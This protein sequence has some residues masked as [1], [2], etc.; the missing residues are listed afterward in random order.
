MTKY[1]SQELDSIV[2]RKEGVWYI[3]P[4]K[5]LRK[6]NKVT[7]DAFPLFEQIN[8]I[9]IVNHE[10]W[11]YSPNLP[12]WDIDVWYM[13]PGQEDNLITLEWNRFVDLYDPKTKKILNFEISYERIKLGWEIIHK[14]PAILGWNI[15]VFHKN[16][17]PNGSI[18]QNFAV[19]DDKFDLDTEFNIYKLNTKTGEYS[20]ARFWKED[21]PN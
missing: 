14:W 9:D 19:R 21:Q 12:N 15:W 8:W 16:Y 4:I 6:T 2:K 7:F 17:S 20:V 18:S 1:L 5:V 10:P 13:H 3:I 11:A